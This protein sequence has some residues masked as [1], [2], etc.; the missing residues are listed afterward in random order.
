[1]ILMSS[2][3]NSIIPLSPVLAL[4]LGELVHR[5]P[6]VLAL[7]LARETEHDLLGLAMGVPCPRSGSSL[8]DSPF[9]HLLDW[10]YHRPGR[11]LHCR[12]HF[13]DVISVAVRLFFTT[14]SD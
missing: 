6:Q 4:P 5:V 11:L 2:N 14:H 12:F 7:Q 3:V 10:L 9:S 8:H 1:M 13:E